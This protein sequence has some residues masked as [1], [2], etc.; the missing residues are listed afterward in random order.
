MFVFLGRFSGLEYK[1]EVLLNAFKIVWREVPKSLLMLV[2]DRLP[3]TIK[4]NQII[5]PNVKIIG[6]GT[7]NEIKN[8]IVAADVCIGPLG[9]TRAITLKGLE[10]MACGKPIVTGINSVSK[11]LAVNG[12]NCMCVS[13]ECQAVA[14]F[15]M[16]LL[17][18]EEYALLLGMNARKIV[19]KFSWDRIVTDLE[20]TLMDAVIKYNS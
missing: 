7:R 8:F 4:K 9:S 19:P 13:L 20:K 3:G 1:I 12:I 17:N 15:I 14:D 11:D 16:K 2:D 5:T 10:Y 6:P 18:D